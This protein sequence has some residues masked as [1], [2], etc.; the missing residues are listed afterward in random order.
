MLP[1]DGPYT[2]SDR[3]ANTINQVAADGCPQQL[4]HV[5][6]H[7]LVLNELISTTGA[8]LQEY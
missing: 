5:L 2:A 1:L 6:I 4:E 7:K 8:H 3:V